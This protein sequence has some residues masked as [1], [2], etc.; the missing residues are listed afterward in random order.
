MTQ[1]NVNLKLGLDASPLTQ[2]LQKAY[3]E[4]NRSAKKAAS[5]NKP[6]ETSLEKVVQ[7]AKKLGLQ[8][9]KV[10]R[11]F[12]DSKGSIQTL[13]QVKQRVD[14]LNTSLA[15]TKQ[16]ATS[17]LGGIGEGFKQVLQ[18]I[19]QGI[20]LAIGQ[21][22]LAPLTN[23]QSVLTGAVGGAVRTFVDI[24]EAL[25][26]TASI[27]GAT[28]GQFLQLQDAVIGLAKDTAFTT[29]E[30]A[31]ASIALARAGFTAQEVEEALP[32]VAE[33]AAAAGQSMDQMSDVV[34]SAMGGFQKG[35]DE[36]IDVV[37]VLTQTANMSNQSVVDLGE[38]L[39]YVG[40]IANG[41]GLSLEDTAAA[42][43]LLANAGIRGSQAGTTLRSGLGRLA[44]AAAGNN[45]EFSELSR[46]TGRL[47]TTI[48]KLGADIV[49]SNGNLK[50]MPELLKTLK[51]AF[52]NLSSTESQLVAKILFGDEAAAGFR[53]LL[54]NTTEDIDKFAAATNNA[55]GVAA[56]TAQKNL[57]G[58]AGSLK[59]LSSAFDAA[60]ATVGKF[61]QTILKPLVD[62]VAAVLNAF[63]GLP[64][65]IQKGVIAITAL[66]TA[67][68]LTTAAFVAFKAAASVG[69]FEGLA[70]VFGG[71]AGAA[72][73]ATGAMLPLTTAT[74]AQAGAS[75]LLTGVT[76]TLGGAFTALSG[77]IKGAVVGAYG[78]LTGAVTAFNALMTKQIALKGV[79]S[80]AWG[81]LGA[82]MKAIMALNMKS[83]LM[84]ILGGLNSMVAGAQKA[85]T[86]LQ[87]AGA[88]MKA[89][90]AAAAPLAA[91]AAAVTATAVAWD[92]YAKSQAGANAVSEGAAPIQEKLDELLKKQGVTVAK[93]SEE[94]KRSVEAVG[95]FQARLDLLRKS[96]GLATVE[97]A[98]VAQ[99]TNRL[100]EEYGGIIDKVD[101]ATSSYR[102][103]A[104]ALEGMNLEDRAAALE[105]LSEQER[106]IRESIAASINELKKQK[107]TL[108]ANAGGVE[109]LTA[110]KKEQI[111]I[112]QALIQNLTASG[113]VLDAIKNK[114]VATAQAAKEA[115]D[116]IKEID[117]AEALKQA[118]AALAAAS[119]SFK[120]KL[121]NMQTA[122]NSLKASMDE[123][124]SVKVEGIKEQIAAIK[125][126][127][128]ATQDASAEAK[129]A[130]QA[131][132]E[133]RVN[134]VERAKAASLAA[135][136]EEI[137]QI[138]KK[139]EAESAMYG[140][141]IQNLEKQKSSARGYYDMVGRLS[142][143]N[144]ERTMQQFG[145]ELETLE[146]QKAAVASRYDAAL[147]RL[148][149]LTPAEKELARIEKQR[150]QDAARAGGEEGL[151]AKAQLERMEASK[152]A[153][154][155]ERARAEELAQLEKQAE[156]RKALAQEK[157]KAFADEIEERKNE[158]AARELRR[159]E[160]IDQ[161]REKQK[162]AQLEAQTE[163][164]GVKA[165]SQNKEKQFEAQM[166][167]IRRQGQAQIQAIEAEKVQAKGE[168][169]EIEKQLSNEIKDL[170]KANAEAKK[171]AEQDYNEKRTELLNNF[172]KAIG[173]TNSKIVSGGKVAWGEYADNAVAELAKVERA[174]N[175][176]AA[177]AI[178]ARRL[179]GS[180][181][182]SRWTGGPVSAGQVYTVNELGQE[183]F[184]SSTGKI[185]MIDAPSY[186]Q[187]RAPSKGTVINAAQTERMGLP[188]KLAT[189]QAP[190]EGARIDSSGGST[191]ATVSGS[192]T[193]NLLRAIAKA[194]GGDKITNNVT[195]QAANT[196]QA[197]SDMMVELTKLKRR[198]FG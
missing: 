165:E 190:S 173:K 7:S 198:R 33:G 149:Q 47:S 125:E 34:I 24:D 169:A 67:V 77:V 145:R 58:F 19:P 18:G 60:S 110:K 131:E 95:P 92:T 112:I 162:Q 181:G 107:E 187:W 11:T 144:H 134:G 80:G 12:R 61:L 57:E 37:D 197:A 71:V 103:Q 117:P 63:N 184:R 111:N 186:G 178:R 84:G 21:Q 130:V 124:L 119:E 44:A 122:F 55:T 43:G 40:P 90:I 81:K 106:A 38:S 151:R 68:G 3:G 193:R 51:G 97:S 176:A 74:T 115:N 164:D 35:T 17:A 177:A 168:T 150:L 170:E 27:S 86:A 161:L 179:A 22:L 94:W 72:T 59:L 78:L 48:K 13:A 5:A 50:A 160:Q 15:K 83:V 118:D 192:E 180:S 135:S 30:L 89:F 49:D 128:Q 143:A 102:K 56:E 93:V 155:L 8:Y 183:A 98:K 54:A 1:G 52:A 108:I 152:K 153:A 148:R 159:S 76:A 141:A 75:T 32:G 175:A 113:S 46:G 129:A 53:A 163:I 133:A 123:G 138:Q 191:T 154:E 66:G 101:G 73:G 189:Q 100:A 2:G 121:A 137:A 109:N 65:P 120:G 96:L 172:N 171:E 79:A 6:V 158:A 39:K 104:E 10:N 156:E 36:T 157:E 196:T 14:Q 166:A 188:D 174:A 20:G 64:A 126:Q 140:R 82:A 29:G 31:N 91:V 185:S 195:I 9:D 116:K 87:V 23:F 139:G 4:L 16:V 41:L 146:R 114:Y 88:K 26:Q 25:R 136:E 147:A 167:E 70:G 62:G 132:T 182:N 42:L 69:L 45:S 142:Q 85:G 99:E 194:T 127:S 105:K 28:E